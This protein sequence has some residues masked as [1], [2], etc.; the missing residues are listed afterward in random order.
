MSAEISASSS[1]DSDNSDIDE[2]DNQH[3]LSRVKRQIEWCGVDTEEEQLKVAKPAAIWPPPQDGA[4]TSSAG[5]SGTNLHS[6]KNL[7]HVRVGN[8]LLGTKMQ[9]YSKTGHFLAVYPDG[10][11]RG[12]LDDNDLHTYLELQSAGQA[13]HVRIKGLLSMMYVGMNKKGR[14]YAEPDPTEESTIFIE[15]FQ[16][17]Y[18]TYLSKL[19]AHLGWFIGIKK[20]GRPKRGHKTGYRQKAVKFLSVRKKFE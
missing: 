1:S 13:G 2:H 7:R 12:T 6:W 8:P 18:K 9:L 19:Y 15:S 10:T 5:T 14:L 16:G 17:Y 4:S 3:Q 20:S 11:V